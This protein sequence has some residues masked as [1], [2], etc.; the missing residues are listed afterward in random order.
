MLLVEFGIWLYLLPKALKNLRKVL[1]DGAGQ[2]YSEP[3]VRII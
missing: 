2:D 3:E 1:T